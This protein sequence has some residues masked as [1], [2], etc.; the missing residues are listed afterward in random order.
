MLAR[1]SPYNFSLASPIAVRDAICRHFALSFVLHAVEGFA[2]RD[3]GM[4][5]RTHPALWQRLVVLFGA[6]AIVLA[7]A[8]APVKTIWV[9]T[10]ALALV[11]VPLIAFR[12]LAAYGLFEARD[13]SD[14]TS[15]PRVPD[16]ELP[17]YTLLVPLYREAHMLPA[18]I[19]V[20]TRLDTRH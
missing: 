1:L 5:A 3:P 10:L 15:Y 8:L 12:L 19:T 17:I 2:S 9:V 13:D 6:I 7:V 14:R 20:L 18:L 4:S 11:F 16:H